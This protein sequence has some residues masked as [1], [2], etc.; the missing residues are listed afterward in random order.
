M[1]QAVEKLDEE[2]RYV[3]CVA[4]KS[5]TIK[6]GK[7]GIENNNIYTIHHKDLC[8]VVHKCKS[9][10]YISDD[11]EKVKDWIKS[12]QNVIDSAS[13]KLGTVIPLTFDV[14]VKGSNKDIVEWLKKDYEQLENILKKIKNKQEFGVQIFWDEKKIGEKIAETNQ[15]IQ[16]LRRAIE[17]VSEGEAYFYKNTIETIL[18]N[19]IE[20]NADEYFKK[21]YNIIKEY[22][23]ELKIDKIKKEKDKQM[24]MNLSCLVHKNKVKKLG[25]ELEKINRYDEFSVKFTGPWPPYSFVSPG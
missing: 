5:K 22:V 9:Q 11:E 4:N 16:N 20:K 6:F 7:I 19:E 23:D 18:K 13:Q 3:Y 8:A 24:L 10:A 14:I 1:K 25:A 17:K 15:E 21:F 12:H 2:G